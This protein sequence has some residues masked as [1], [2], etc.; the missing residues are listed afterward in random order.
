MI[1]RIVDNQHIKIE[2]ITSDIEDRLIKWFSARHPN[3]QFMTGISFSH[4]Y[5]GVIRRYNVRKQQLALPFLK[6]LT[7]NC[8]KAR[9]PL[10]VI[11]ERPPYACPTSPEQITDQWLPGITLNPYQVESIKKTCIVDC[12]ILQAPTGAGKSE[13]IAGIIKAHQCPTIVLAEQ[14][15]IVDQLRERL[16][17]RDI[18]AEVG[19]FYAGKT[20]EDKVV[21]VGT[22]MAFFK[23]PEPTASRYRPENYVQVYQAWQTRCRNAEKYRKIMQK[24]QLLIVD[25][26]DKASNK[27]YRKIF[28]FW[29]KGRKRFGCSATPFD[30][31]KPVE[32]LYIREHFGPIIHQ[33]RRHEVEQ[34]GRIIPIRYVMIAVGENE[35]R[36]DDTMFDVAVNEKIVH[37]EE[38]HQLVVKI[39][40]A[41]PDDGTLILV[42]RNELGQFLERLI[43]DAKF[44]YGQT[45]R[46]QRRKIFRQF[47]QRKIKCL[48]GGKIVKRGFDL[49]GGCENLIICNTGKLR[50]DFLQQV[51]RAL[52]IN[53][54]GFA[55]VFDFYYLNNKYLYSHSRKRLKFVLSE[56]YHAMVKFQR[57]SIL[58]EEL[59]K[60]RFRIPKF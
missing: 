46:T 37:N 24:C 32:N 59:V 5:D 38:Y 49:K 54:K 60:R 7:T 15:V 56:G 31:D 23:P 33:V 20:V 21:C 57:G 16:E 50:S 35:N 41:F 4:D 44:V 28:R 47:E 43:P 34:C 53:S 13:C 8:F 22:S 3:H 36:Y 26:C 1:A 29:F 6:E 40:K 51:G 27:V 55:R 19:L 9:I 14:T 10:D 39:V 12:G 45:S 11:D 2:Q 42:E 18:A 52:R 17:L 58:G 30:P 48:I 25:E